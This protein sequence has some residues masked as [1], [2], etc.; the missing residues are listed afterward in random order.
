[1][2][3]RPCRH[4]S[5]ICTSHD[6]HFPT[7][8]ISLFFPSI[9]APV[10]SRGGLRGRPTFFESH[11]C[12]PHRLGYPRRIDG[13]A[14][15]W[16]R[17]PPGAQRISVES[18]PSDRRRVVHARCAGAESLQGLW[19]NVTSNSYIRIISVE[20]VNGLEDLRLRKTGMSTGKSATLIWGSRDRLDSEFTIISVKLL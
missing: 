8:A 17:D 11:R 12:A 10:D 15:G 19:G 5:C 14:Y 9:N 20:R 4:I 7:S 16:P 6:T 1:M 18:K 2:N 13:T 3:S